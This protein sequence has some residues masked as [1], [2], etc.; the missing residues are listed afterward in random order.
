VSNSLRAS[1]NPRDAIDQIRLSLNSDIGKDLIYILVEGKD[2]YK[3]YAKLFDQK[4]TNIEYVHGKGNVSTALNELDI[5][6][7][8]IIGICDADFNH[9][10]NI[11]PHIHNLFLTDFHDIEM[12]MLSINGVLND[13]LTEYGL[14]NNTSTILQR[15][16][17]ETKIIGYI[18]WLNQVELIKL[19]FDGLG[20]GRF[21]VPH[22]IN[23]HLDIDAYLCALNKR[24]N[25]KTKTLTL[26][27]I[28]LF[29]Q[30]HNKTDLFNLCN[31]HD[32]TALIAL[33]IGN[34]ASSKNFCSVLRATFN[35]HY[36]NKT[37]LYADIQKWQKE[38][39]Y[40]ILRR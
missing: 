7:K 40:I 6:T 8:Q 23:A 20:L 13:A 38:N 34:G 25:S 33:I 36:F 12:T 18:R 3:N 29:I 1:L 11:T 24:S 10:Q 22:N 26:A 2:D 21:V 19:D 4:K 35:I 9:L 16:F 15:A 14:Q 5:I 17:E 37:K 31:G 27:D 30:M 39:G 28:T 32:V